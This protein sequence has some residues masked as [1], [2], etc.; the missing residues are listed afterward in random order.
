MIARWW[1]RR[2]GCGEEFAGT[3]APTSVGLPVGGTVLVLGVLSVLLCLVS[4]AVGSH[5]LTLEE[6]AGAFVPGRTTV[7]S[8]IVWQL[9][10]PR[11]VLAVMVGASLAVA[12]VVMQG[13]TRNPLAEPGILGINA[14]A[15]LSVVM[16]MSLLGLTDV[17]DFLW[18]AFAGAALA[19]F[20]VHLM[21]V[22][23]A[24]AGPARL[25]LAGVAL[26]ASLRSIT[27]TITM[28]DSVTFD[29]YRFW[30]LG[31]LAD[32]DAV[33]LVW[34]VPFLAVGLVLAL[35]SGLTLNALALGEEQ[36]KALG[37]SPRRARALALTSI[38]LLCGA[39]TAA[40]GPISFVGL[41]V[42]QVLRLAL[43]ADQ[44]RLLAVS[45]VAGPVLLLAADVVG[46]VIL[47]SGE[48]EAG[49]V[50]AFIGGP[51]LLVMVIQRMGVR[52]R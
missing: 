18:F 4:L 40:V 8:V 41:V 47:E 9:R 2:R 51:V 29:S 36:A 32:R 27:G 35:V 14:G 23:S 25:V 20:L 6:V 30:V 7:A 37:V 19:A 28:Y 26:G 52:G 21:S 11:T 31:S 49:V 10:M 1:E 50:T 34:V 3:S 44:R 45:L 22:P 38:T 13:L 12:G 17:S 42:P 5:S 48:M 46:R 33:L 24:D 15:S 39:S 16:S 43:G